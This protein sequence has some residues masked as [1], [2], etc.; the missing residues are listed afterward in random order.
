MSSPSTMYASQG[1]MRGQPS[2]RF[3]ARIRMPVS[4]SRS[5]ANAASSGAPAANSFQ[6]V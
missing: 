2:A 4:R 5:W 1:L 6:L 3:V